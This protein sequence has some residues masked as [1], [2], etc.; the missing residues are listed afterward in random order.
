MKKYIF[1]FISLSFA[2]KS[3]S[4]KL[5]KVISNYEITKETDAEIVYI[6]GTIKKGTVAYVADI[7]P[8]DSYFAEKADLIGQ[9]GKVSKADLKMNVDGYYTGDFT[10]DNGKKCYFY[11]VK[12]SLNPVSNI[13][14]SESKFN[15]YSTPTTKIKTDKDWN[16]ALNDKS[17]KMNDAVVVTAI[18]PD[19]NL[20]AK[21]DEYI[22][23]DAIAGDD[24]QYNTASDSYEGTLNFSNGKSIYFVLI[25]LKKK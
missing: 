15:P 9:R 23:L 21:K 25:K 8:G 4:K 5:E 7:N 22:G 6:T 1:L 2:V 12:F 13:A 19:D 16:D 14:S 3:F 11:R 18:N 20:F 17:I 10:L 24:L